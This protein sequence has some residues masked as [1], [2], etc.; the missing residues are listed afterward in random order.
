MAGLR[1]GNGASNHIQMVR[2]TGDNADQSHKYIFAM[3]GHLRRAVCH[4]SLELIYL[5]ST[6]ASQYG[7]H[8]SRAKG[9]AYLP[10]GLSFA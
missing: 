2:F 6:L 10:C 3:S 1:I 4:N 5:N 8:L 7:L 9:K